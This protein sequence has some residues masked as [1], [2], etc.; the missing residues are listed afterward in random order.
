MPLTIGKQGLAG[1]LQFGRTR[2]KEATV[3]LA[4]PRTKQGALP[5]QMLL[6]SAPVAPRVR[7]D[8]VLYQRLRRSDCYLP[9][10]SALESPQ[11]HSSRLGADS[12]MARWPAQS[13]PS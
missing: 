5:P 11:F 3:A 8:P 6:R 7:F 1:T 2:P 10:E 4:I 12:L 9:E 13:P